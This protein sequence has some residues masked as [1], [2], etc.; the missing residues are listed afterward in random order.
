MGA[1]KIPLFKHKTIVLFAA[2]AIAL[3]IA[4]AA[5]LDVAPW[6]TAKI[7]SVAVIMLCLAFVLKVTLPEEKKRMEEDAELSFL[8]SQSKFQDIV[9]E[10]PDP[11]VTL[12]N[13]GFF[14]YM[15]KAA[16]KVSG[17]SRKELLG[18]HFA[19]LGIVAQDSMPL[20]MK[21][22][23]KSISGFPAGAPYHLDLLRKNGSEFTAE[24]NYQPIVK[25]G[26]VEG[27]ELVFRYFGEKRKG[28]AQKKEK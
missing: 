17:Y 19:D 12:D 9:E 2:I 4:T 25:K 5:L 16:E 27:I 7:Q 3:S 18:K 20:A 8:S 26:K 23:A 24:V 10:A 11:I 22:F 1:I 21:E 28:K 14:T 15:N 13:K 6:I